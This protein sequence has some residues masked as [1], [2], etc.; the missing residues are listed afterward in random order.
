MDSETGF[1]A[2]NSTEKILIYEI[3]GSDIFVRQR[4][5]WIVKVSITLN[6]ILGYFLAIPFYLALVHFEKFG[7]DPMK[8]TLKNRIIIFNSYICISMHIFPQTFLSICSIF[9]P[10]DPTIAYLSSIWICLSGFLLLLSTAQLVLLENLMIFKFSLINSID[11]RFAANFL[12]IWNLAFASGFQ[13]FL[14]YFEGHFLVEEFEFMTA[15]KVNQHIPFPF[16]WK[17]HI[18]SCGVVIVLGSFTKKFKQFT[19]AQKDSKYNIQAQNPHLLSGIEISIVSLVVI[20]LVSIFAC[21]RLLENVNFV[22]FLI[23]I[24][25]LIFGLILPLTFTL[26]KKGFRNHIC[27]NIL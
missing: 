12:V 15:R 4:S 24:T 5:D 20:F 23:I 14:S 10:I 25:G 2:E 21:G 13:G 6:W 18:L 9:G 8:R 26:T 7:H 3:S 19:E 22:V 27:Q 11:E 17:I 1:W 16:L